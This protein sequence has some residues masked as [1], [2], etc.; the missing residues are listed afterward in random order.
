MN[1]TL[2]L[3]LQRLFQ[4]W[5][6]THDITNPQRKKLNTSL[7]LMRRFDAEDEEE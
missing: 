3:D 6:E 1:S 4:E 7:A 2:F 5:I